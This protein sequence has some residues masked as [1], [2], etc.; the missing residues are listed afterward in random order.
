[1]TKQEIIDALEG[2][3]D[4]INDN[5]KRSIDSLKTAVAGL[6]DAQV[7][8]SSEEDDDSDDDTDAKPAKRLVKSR[9]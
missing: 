7:S 2:L 9:R 5:G 4:F 1:M 3:K 8:S 6:S